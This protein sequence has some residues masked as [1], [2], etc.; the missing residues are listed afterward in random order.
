[1]KTFK[2]SLQELKTESVIIY[3]GDE[4]YSLL[5]NPD[6]C[7]LLDIYTESDYF[8]NDFSK[9]NQ[10][11]LYFVCWR[12]L[13]ITGVAKC[14]INS[15]Y[16]EGKVLELL[17]IEVIPKHQ[18]KGFASQIGK[19]MFDYCKRSNYIFKSAPYTKKGWKKIKPMFKKL[20][21]EMQI[22][23]IDLDIKDEVKMN[24]EFL[25][26]HELKRSYSFF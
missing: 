24:F 25:N 7:R 12:G 22:P 9:W 17:Y 4:L 6:N 20:S 8:G 14:K 15:D 18:N 11:F 1:M 16:E 26:F 10:S 5:H 2:D 23:F 19:K 21:N 3:S 13:D